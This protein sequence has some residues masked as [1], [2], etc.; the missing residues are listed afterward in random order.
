[1]RKLFKK[2][3]SVVALHTHTHTDS[4]NRKKVGGVEK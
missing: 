3:V 2:R 4:F 1:M